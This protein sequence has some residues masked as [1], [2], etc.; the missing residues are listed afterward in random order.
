MAIWIPDAAYEMHFGT[1]ES[2]LAQEVLKDTFV[3]SA[4][5]MNLST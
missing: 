1:T 3:K 4:G 5:K 2:I